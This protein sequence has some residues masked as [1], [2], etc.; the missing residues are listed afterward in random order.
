MEQKAINSS[1]ADDQEQQHF[2]YA[3]HLVTL[4]VFPFTLQAAFE[5][6][7]FEILTKA[8][9]G[10]ELSA[11]EIAA[12]ITAT[13]PNAAS[14]VDRILRLL[15]THSVVGCSTAE[16]EGGNVK[17][18]YSLTPVSKYFVRN[19]DGV[20]LGPVME[21]IQDKVFL[22]SWRELKNAV[23]EG[24]VAFNRAHG[25]VHAFEYPGLDPRFNKVFNTAMINHT[26]MGIKKIVESYKGFGNLNQLV[27]VGG[28]LGVTLQVI[29]S[30]Y[31]SIKG[32]NFDLPHVIRDAPAYP[33]VEHIGGDMFESVPKGDAIFM[34]WI[35]HDWSDEHC[36]KLLK[37]C[38]AA[39]PNDGKVIAVD[40]VVP[41][42]IET[43][44]TMKSIT[45]GDVLMMTQNPGGK[46]RTRDEFKALATKTG[47]KR[48]NFECF[49]YNLWVIE[50]IK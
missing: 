12:K 43:T 5:L 22:D 25:G 7:V 42:V 23:I 39:I 21:L 18:L 8:G 48:I 31:P 33:G 32:I 40:A 41:L 44:I 49:V 19:E 29:T 1:S 13:N 14:M 47:F 3:A 34:K 2:A 35:L 45:Q 16:D 9:P 50:F 38:Y 20:S 27:D 15:A 10:A 11:A 26:T 30:K 37:N 6:G 24:G 36:V 46:E 4:S 28:G 17:R